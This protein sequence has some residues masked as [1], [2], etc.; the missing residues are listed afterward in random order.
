M[1]KIPKCYWI[2]FIQDSQWQVLSSN[3]P[4]WST[5][6]S[7][8]L[9]RNTAM[10]PR[11][12]LHLRSLLNRNPTTGRLWICWLPT[13]KMGC[14]KKIACEITCFFS[15]QQDHEYPN[16]IESVQW[17]SPSQFQIFPRCK[18]LQLLTTRE[19][20]ADG[21]LPDSN[22]AISTGSTIMMPFL[23]RWGEDFSCMLHAFRQFHKVSKDLGYSK[24]DSFI[25]VQDQN[26]PSENIGDHGKDPG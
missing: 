15:N 22:M 8:K 17:I 26:K 11:C 24:L 19:S 1:T 23:R 7:L 25:K 18:S 5:M 12:R 16:L 2:P 4:S 13:F 14:Q 3:P 9:P 10:A 21:V 6:T 20:L